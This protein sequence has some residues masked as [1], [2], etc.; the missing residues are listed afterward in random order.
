MSKKQNLKLKYKNLNKK[1]KLNFKKKSKKCLNIE[2]KYNKSNFKIISKKLYC[3][4]KEPIVN[5]ITKVNTVWLI[6]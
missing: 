1:Q 2:K 4:R 6:A 3:G 5:S